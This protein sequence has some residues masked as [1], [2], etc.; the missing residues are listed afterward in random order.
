MSLL[1]GDL[2]DKCLMAMYD[3]LEGR[4]LIKNKNAVLVLVFD[5]IMLPIP[6]KSAKVTKEQ[7]CLDL[8]AAIS[9]ATGYEVKLIVKD[10][11]EGLDIPDDED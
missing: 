1:Y 7:L 6:P 9:Q 2:E 3:M 8:T 10:M 5:G 4:G 11:D